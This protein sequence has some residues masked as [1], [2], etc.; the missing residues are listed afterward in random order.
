[1]YLRMTLEIFTQHSC[2][3]SVITDC[4]PGILMLF[5]VIYGLNHL[6]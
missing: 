2:P 6:R 1:M 4:L 3:H 5:P